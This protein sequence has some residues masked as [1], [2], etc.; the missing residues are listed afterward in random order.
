MGTSFGTCSR[1]EKKAQCG[2]YAVEFMD[3]NVDVCEPCYYQLQALIV[4]WYDTPR[5]Q[6]DRIKGRGRGGV[7][8]GAPLGEPPGPAGPAGMTMG[9]GKEE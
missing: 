3:R 5:K 2:M 9:G 1:C 8:Q 7:D 6:G 4:A